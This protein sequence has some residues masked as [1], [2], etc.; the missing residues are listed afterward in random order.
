M[1][2]NPL[3]NFTKPSKKQQIKTL[4]KQ[5]NELK[6]SQEELYEAM[7]LYKVESMF[8]KRIL[9]LF[10]PSLRNAKPIIHNLYLESLQNDELIDIPDLIDEKSA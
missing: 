8:Y 10:I 4:I 5:L 2:N 3:P 6:Q 9:R 1:G 7:R